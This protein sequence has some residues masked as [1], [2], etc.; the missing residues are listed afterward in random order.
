MG[1]DIDFDA[2]RREFP[3]VDLSNTDALDAVLIPYFARL[4]A[5]R[6][7]A[8]EGTGKPGGEAMRPSNRT[9]P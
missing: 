5:N 4:R 9:T 2:I 1:K 3:E 6:K 8:T 7:L